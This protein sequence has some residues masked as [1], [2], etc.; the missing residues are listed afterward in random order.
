LLGKCRLRSGL[1]AILLGVAAAGCGHAA[2]PPTPSGA[3]LFAEDCQACHSLIGNESLHKQGG[4]LL[5]YSMSHRQ[6][7]SFAREMP[8]R[9]RLSSRQLRAVVDFVI[10]AE[11]ASR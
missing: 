6:M 8:V 9:R 11:E 1:L 7:T 4:D 5:G 2:S 10:H 3:A